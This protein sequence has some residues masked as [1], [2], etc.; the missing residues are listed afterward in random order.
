MHPHIAQL[1]GS[2][3]E[4][5]DL[6]DFL[7]EETRKAME[8]SKKQIE[9]NKAEIKEYQEDIQYYQTVIDKNHLNQLELFSF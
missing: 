6:G 5:K 3:Y 9:E 8:Y 7:N 2:G 1:F 4:E